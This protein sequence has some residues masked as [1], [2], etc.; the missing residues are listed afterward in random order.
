MLPGCSSGISDRVL[1]DWINRVGEGAAD[2]AQDLEGREVK[3][4]RV[5]IVQQRR[6]RCMSVSVGE[7]PPQ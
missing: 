3:C 2:L 4:S 5:S 1:L 7:C 6:E